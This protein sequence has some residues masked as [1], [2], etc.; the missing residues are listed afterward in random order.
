MASNINGSNPTTGSPTTESVRVNFQAARDEINRELRNSTDS[1][2]AT[3]TVNALVATYT[4]PVV[5][6][7]GVR[8]V[9]KPTGANTGAVT[10][11]VNSTGVS[12]VVSQVGVALSAGQISG[13]S[14]YL[15]LMW[16]ATSSYWVL[17]NPN[18]AASVATAITSDGNTPSLSTNIDAQEIRTLIGSVSFL[19]IY[20]EGC[21]YTTVTPG[22]PSA[23]FGGT[24]DPFGAGKVLVG[25]NSAETEFNPVEHIGGDKT[26]TLT[27]AQ[28]GLP[29]HSHTQQG[30][31]FNG[32]VGIEPGSSLSSSLGETGTTGG[33]DALEA[34]TNLQPYIVVY[35]WKRTG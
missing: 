19:D 26:V 34:H 24:W 16:D 2:T 13:S 32:N 10:L 31:G 29:S 12:S 9:V 30:G 33:T 4:Y 6:S 21:I 7:E 23:L 22:N 5:K 1:V 20:P 3:G 28:S 11:N 25:F 17:L 14:H 27:A 8:V 18:P 15:D 35:M